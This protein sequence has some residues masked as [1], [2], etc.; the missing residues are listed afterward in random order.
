MCDC[1]DKIP[2]GGKFCGKCGKCIYLKCE[3]HY[4]LDTPFCHFC[5]KGREYLSFGNAEKMYSIST[6]PFPSEVKKKLQFILHDNFFTKDFMYF[7]TKEDAIFVE[8]VLKKYYLRYVNK[9]LKTSLIMEHEIFN[10]VTLRQ[11]PDHHQK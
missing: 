11:S 4:T 7:S 6:S 9:N 1:G 3:E 8:N 2:V 10:T 5:G